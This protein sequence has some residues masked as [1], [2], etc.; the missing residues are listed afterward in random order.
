MAHDTGTPLMITDGYWMHIRH[1]AIY[2]RHYP[3]TRGEGKS[4]GGAAIH[5]MNQLTRGLDAV[6]GR[7]REALER[8]LGDIGA[9]R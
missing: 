2:H 8:A 4:L 5:L 3:E 7:E 6:H 9:I 1:V